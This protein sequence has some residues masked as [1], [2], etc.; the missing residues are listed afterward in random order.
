MF[1][2][3]KKKTIYKTGF[4]QGWVDYHCHIL[5]AVDDGFSNLEDSLEALH[6]YERLGIAEVWLTPHT[7]ED[8]P[9]TTDD[10]RAKF[11]SFQ[12]SYLCDNESRETK[13]VALHLASEYMMDNLFEQHLSNND[14]LTIGNGNNQVLVE[15]S[16]FNPPSH[17]I[18]KLTRLKKLG[19][20]PLLAHPERYMY[21]DFN[22][23][24]TLRD[25]DVRFQLNLA[26]LSGG[27][28]SH[29]KK[30]ALRL[31]KENYYYYGGTD[32]HRLETLGSIL[33]VDAS[34]IHFIS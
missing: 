20:F 17:L 4:L 3:K 2:F 30:K 23:Y 16:Y 19:Y 7:M 32:L 31:L 24:K 5:P 8:M 21:M 9:N 15:T 6:A 26:S 12:E 33:D 1:L 10:L 29:V 18:D 34:P 11:K 25:M 14:F 22:D 13:P 28:G 27:Y